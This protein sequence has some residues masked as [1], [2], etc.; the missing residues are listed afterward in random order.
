VKAGGKQSLLSEDAG[1][2]FF[3][4]VRFALL[5]TCLHAGFLL[6]YP[7]D[8]SDF[9]RK[10]GWLLTDYTALRDRNDRR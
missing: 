9:L 4:N 3:R 2:V 6:F 1:D 7:E 10:V 8:G 5:A